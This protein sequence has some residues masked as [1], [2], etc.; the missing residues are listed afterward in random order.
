[1]RNV[2]ADFSFYKLRPDGRIL[3]GGAI[4]KSYEYP[5]ATTEAVVLQFAGGDLPLPKPLRER[6]AVEYLHAGYG[7]YFFTVDPEEIANLDTSIPAAWARTGRTFE[8]WDENDGTLSLVCRFWSD[9]SYA[10]KSSHAYSPY[11]HE[12]E[13]LKAGSVWRFERD[14]FFLRMPE[15]TPGARTCAGGSRPLYRAYNN[16]ITG[17]PNHRYTPDVA[18]LDGVVAQGWTFEGEVQTKVFACVP[19]I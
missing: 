6:Q 10:P 11:T 9:P 17:A 18:L 8:V 19:V 2:G 16:G 1:M 7:H 5:F 15:G 13:T 14:A 4:W 3:V 12:C